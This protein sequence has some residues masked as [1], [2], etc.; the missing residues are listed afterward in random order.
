MDERAEDKRHDYQKKPKMKRTI[1]ENL[2]DT[3]GASMRQNLS[4]GFPTK[5]DSNQPAQLQ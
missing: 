4:S 3:I 1:S 2:F 5:G